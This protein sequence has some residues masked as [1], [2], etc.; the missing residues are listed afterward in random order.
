MTHGFRPRGEINPS[1]KGNKKVEVPPRGRAVLEIRG[2]PW[3]W[4]LGCPFT[5]AAFFFFFFFFFS[6]LLPMNWAGC[7]KLGNNLI[8]Y[9]KCPEVS[10]HAWPTGYAWPQTGDQA[11]GM[12]GSPPRA[13][14]NGLGVFH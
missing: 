8:K 7:T 3:F 6:A 2:S 1:I 9:P 10:R 4:A 13:L 12:W 11:T 5:A 14:M